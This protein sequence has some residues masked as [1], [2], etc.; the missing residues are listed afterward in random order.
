MAAN[1]MRLSGHL[2]ALAEHRVLLVNRVFPPDVASSGQHAGDVVRGLGA[3]GIRVTV[4]TGRRG[5]DDPKLRFP[6]R[7]GIEGARVLRLPSTWRG[8]ASMWSRV[9]DSLG[10]LLSFLARGLMLPG[11]DCIV[12]MS[13]P[14]L[15]PVAAAVLAAVRRERLVIWLMD[16]NPD[17]AVAAGWLR[18]ES[19]L[20]RVLERMHRWSLHRAESVVV[21]DRFMRE[22]ILAKGVPGHK[23]NVIPPWAHDQAVHYDRAGREEF[24]RRH[25]LSGKFVVMYSGNHSPCHP[26]DTLLEAALRM[27]LREDIAFCFA[28][29]GSEFGKVKT[30]AAERELKNVCCVPYQPLGELSASLSGADLHVIAMGD[31]FVGIVHPCK[32][33]NVLRLGIPFLYIGPPH[34]HIT[35][36]VPEG[37]EGQWAF[38][39]RQGDVE[40]VTRLIARAAELGPNTYEMEEKTGERFSQET[41]VSRMIAAIEGSAPQEDKENAREVCTLSLS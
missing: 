29:G 21:L 27:R 20:A 37:A 12:A 36:L 5:Y 16:L 41:L 18:E 11:H 17:E 22:R 39:A 31:P 9:A 15:L 19:A 23:I 7:A 2:T 34:N 32:I 24:R 4:L 13:S 26:L 38:L 3:Y 30:F 10:F 28:G 35:E 25:G 33:Y 40:G 1:T 14:P 8:K 6:A